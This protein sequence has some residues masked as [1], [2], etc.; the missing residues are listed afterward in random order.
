M[1]GAILGVL[2]YIGGHNEA[3]MGFAAFPFLVFP[4]ILLHLPD[5][6]QAEYIQL[7]L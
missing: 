7:S 2:V 1:S 3:E 5:I 4:F 6:I